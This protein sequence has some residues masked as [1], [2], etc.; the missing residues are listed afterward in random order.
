MS[1]PSDAD[2]QASELDAAYAYCRHIATAHYENFTVGSWLLPRRLR[3]PHRRDLRLRAHR[4]RLRRRGRGA[5]PR[6]AWRVWRRGRRHLEACYAGRA[7]RSGVH[8][9]G[10]HG[11][12]LRD[13][14]RSVPAICWTRFAR[15]SRSS[16]SRRL[17]TCA[18]TA[19]A[20]PIRSGIWSW[21]CSAIA[22]PNAAALADKICTGLQ[23]ANFWQDV[24][25]RCGAG[26][27]STSRSRTCSA[28]AAAPRTSARGEPSR[29]LRELLR[30]EVERARALLSDGLALAAV[31][32][33]RLAREVRLF[34]GGGLAILRRDR[35]AG[36]RRVHVAADSCRAG[37]GPPVWLHSLPQR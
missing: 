36:L 18:T 2:A 22:T 10:R 33:R 31:V 5:A 13:A 4:R 12:A 35:G 14:D 17:P 23:L 29:P 21:R 11:C 1:V 25:R 8:R 20:P 7:S 15:T 9:A 34:A 24:A 6:S 27:A 3:K 32:E 37:E 26:A 30:F 28:S 19:A 16:P